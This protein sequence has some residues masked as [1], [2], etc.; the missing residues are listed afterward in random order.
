MC[1]SGF[2]VLFYYIL[3]SQNEH[4]HEAKYISFVL[5][6]FGAIPGAGATSG[7]EASP[8]YP[9]A[10]HQM[11]PGAVSAVQHTCLCCATSQM[12]AL[13]S[14]WPLFLA[15]EKGRRW[16]WGAFSC[17]SPLSAG[18]STAKHPCC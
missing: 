17:A 18:E 1:V 4:R 13:L 7:S 2:S 12:V 5:E 10:P 14:V 16:Q 6:V 9:V 3:V 8:E 11:Q 15:V